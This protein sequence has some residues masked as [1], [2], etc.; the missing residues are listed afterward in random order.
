MYQMGKRY[1]KVGTIVKTN[2][3]DDIYIY[4]QRT[5]NDTEKAFESNK[6]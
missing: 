1:W 2:Q 5:K 6:K 3:E 4:I